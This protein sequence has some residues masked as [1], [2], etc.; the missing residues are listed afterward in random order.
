M[1]RRTGRRGMLLA[2]GA[3]ACA[4]QGAPVWAHSDDYF[5]SHP[6][7]HGGQT[8]MAGPIHIEL[9][10]QGTQVTLY[11]TDHAGKARPSAG[12]KAALRLG[13]AE[14][15]IELA[16]GPDNTFTGTLAA[17]LAAE[18]IVVAFV[19]LAGAETQTARFGKAPAANAR[20]HHHEQH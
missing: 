2:I 16:P 1:R 12:G 10:A 14:A 3:L 19:Q 17:P 11:I 4:L 20:E 8:R 13:D 7:A 18:T 15:R 9:V 5:D 6:S